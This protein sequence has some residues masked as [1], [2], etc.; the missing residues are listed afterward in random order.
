[1]S[2]VATWKA[3]ASEK[4]RSGSAQGK[5]RRRGAASLRDAL[6]RPGLPRR[7][8]RE[9]FSRADGDLSTWRVPG[10]SQRSASYGIGN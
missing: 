5:G 8:R 7:K 9:P 2:S 6:W 3:P 4:R 1:M 10:T